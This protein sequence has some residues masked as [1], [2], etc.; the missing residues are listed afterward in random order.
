M[1]LAAFDP[2]SCPS[3]NANRFGTGMTLHK[4]AELQGAYAW[5]RNEHQPNNLQNQTSAQR[6]ACT[7]Q[8]MDAGCVAINDNKAY[9]I[10][11]DYQA[12]QPAKSG[13]I[14]VCMLSK[15]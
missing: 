10:D 2:P 9:C 5:Q 15:L 12:S 8:Q 4:I 3:S 7:R 6:Q 1:S 14:K 11:V 13:Q